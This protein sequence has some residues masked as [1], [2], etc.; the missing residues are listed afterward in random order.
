MSTKTI[1]IISLLLSMIQAL[2]AQPLVSIH[3]DPANVSKGRLMLS[4]LVESVEYIPLETKDNCLIGHISCFDVSKNYILLYCSQ[5]NN[6]FLFKRDGRFV[7]KIGSSGQG[8]QEYLRLNNVF[9]DE[10]KN[11]LILCSFNKH[12]FFSLS[13]KFLR[14]V[15]HQKNQTPLWIYYNNQLISGSPSGVFPGIFPVYNIWTLD[16]QLI[17]SGVNS[18]PVENKVEGGIGMFSN[19]AIVSYIY[20]NKLYLRESTLNDT[21]YVVDNGIMPKYILYTGKYGITPEEKGS[22]N[23]DFLTNSANVSSIAETAS[24][25]LFQYRYRKVVYSAFFKKDSG[26]LEYF[27]TNEAGIPNNFDGGL[28]FWPEKQINKEWYCFYDAPTFLNKSA[29]H[30][31]EFSN[32]SQTAS[33]KYKNLVRKID[34]EDN[35]VLVISIIK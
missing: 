25:I 2:F 31:P 14:M 32:V 7:A 18:I 15:S 12:L 16:M 17:A 6:V 11:E 26:K 29:K 8:P 27:D 4:D 35:P 5:T 23:L 3:I 24:Y 30:K 21:V 22:F 10:T 1:L 9:I 28:D 19:P 34:T 13:G 20:E 33:Q